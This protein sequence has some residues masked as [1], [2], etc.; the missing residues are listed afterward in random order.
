MNKATIFYPETESEFWQ[1]ALDDVVLS[2]KETLRDFDECRLGLAGGSTPKKLYESLA[3]QDLPWEKIKLILLDERQVPSDNKASN[4]GMIREALLKKISIPPENILS[5]D[6]SLPP[7][8]AAKEMSRKLVAISHERYPLF[9]LLILGAG[10][11]GHIASLFEGDHA[12]TCHKYASPAKAIG[13]DVEDRLSVC[14][15]GLKS[16]RQVLLLLIGENKSSLIQ[17]I[18]GESSEIK[19][20]ALNEIIES[21]PVKVLAYLK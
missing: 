19:M 3:E 7:E 4:L 6:T 10:A 21:A 16:S 12:L 11:D 9:D 5:F 14:L 13:Y 15:L 17:A 20:T 18:K 2:I 8:S 1:T